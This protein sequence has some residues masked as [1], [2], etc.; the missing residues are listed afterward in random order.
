MVGIG[1]QLVGRLLGLALV[2][3][4][5]ASLAP[6]LR[7]ERFQMRNEVRVDPALAQAMQDSGGKLKVLI[8]ARRERYSLEPSLYEGGLRPSQVRRLVADRNTAEIFSV[9]NRG[10]A[11]D[12]G[13]APSGIESGH[14]VEPP[15]ALP[16][17]TSLLPP[18]PELEAHP[19]S[20]PEPRGGLL[21]R[22]ASLRTRPAPDVSPAA[23]TVLGPGSPGGLVPGAD[24]PG[25]GA[26]RSM[27]PAAPSGSNPRRVTY[28]WAANAV[29][30][31][32]DRATLDE[33]QRTR[34]VDR[35]YLDREI[36]VLVRPEAQGRVDVVEGL[37]AESAESYGIGRIRADEARQVRGLS[38]A[39]IRVGVIDSGVDADHPALAGKVVAF[40]D[41]LKGR[42]EAYD[43][44]GHGTHCAATIAG[45]PGIGVAPGARLVV[46]KALNHQGNGSISGFLE[47]MQWMLDPDGD[48]LTDDEPRIVSNS[49][50]APAAALGETR[51]LFR[52]MVRAWRQAGI[53][54]LFAVGNFGPDVETVPAGYPEA[55]AV[56][57]TDQDDVVWEDSAGSIHEYDG[58]QVVKPDLTA[59]GVAVLSA[60]PDGG[61]AH[62]NGSSMACPHVAGAMA[63]AL[64]ADPD[65]EVDDLEVAFGSSSVELGEEGQDSRYG[66]GRIDVVAGLD[67]L[68][69]IRG[70]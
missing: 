66:E 21:G 31:E 35:I 62:M 60:Y 41:F 2:I 47:A 25:P 43:D 64:E 46:A 39:G 59:P 65:A 16:P 8:V 27:A 23:P 5:T 37:T 36:Q 26:P 32:V 50:G 4:L 70:Q 10:P 12:A 7:A 15:T 63:L 52:E 48:P 22:L 11:P 33:L 34:S 56:G 58:E 3:G 45:P 24:A 55:F 17:G 18:L 57:A 51:D 42:T 13:E 38:G 9:L 6:G 28:L 29:A 20:S 68:G 54:P 67:L 44:L 1:R 61:Y 49:W 19:S 30:T 14:E 53:V 69:R 40:R